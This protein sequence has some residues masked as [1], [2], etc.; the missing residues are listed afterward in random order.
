[1]NTVK[2]DDSVEALKPL[3]EGTTRAVT[4]AAMAM[5]CGL[6]DGMADRYNEK[7]EQER[8]ARRFT[9]RTRIEAGEKIKKAEMLMILH[10]MDGTKKEIADEIKLPLD[11]VKKATKAWW[12]F[13]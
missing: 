8:E 10:W 12:N 7:Q 13:L 4:S 2:Q 3:V 9:L 1:M 6:L 11:V 5:F